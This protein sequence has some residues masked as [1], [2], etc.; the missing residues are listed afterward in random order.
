MFIYFEKLSPKEKWKLLADW[1]KQSPQNSGRFARPREEHLLPI[2]VCFGS[3][4]PKEKF[5]DNSQIQVEYCR[6]FGMGSP[7]S[8]Y[9]NNLQ[10][11][12][13]FFLQVDRFFVVWTIIAQSIIRVSSMF[14]IAP[15]L[16]NEIQVLF[17][18]TKDGEEM[19]SKKLKSSNLMTLFHLFICIFQSNFNSEMSAKAKKKA[20][21][22]DTKSSKSSCTDRKSITKKALKLND[23]GN[24]YYQEKEYRTSIECY[25]QAISFDSQ[26][27]QYNLMQQSKKKKRKRS[28]PPIVS[29]YFKRFGIDLFFF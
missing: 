1:E 5:E 12:F 17:A 23:E 7:L 8:C 29:F 21:R 28:Q 14:I 20:S 2:H 16:S 27:T 19:R 4:F 22:I 25:S 13:F 6:G 11:H 9:I 26:I 15:A 3:S 24:T 18:I 10:T